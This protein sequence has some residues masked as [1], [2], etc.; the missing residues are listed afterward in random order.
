MESLPAAAL[1]GL[2][3]GDIEVKFYDD[4]LEPVPFDEPT[5]LV[6][7]SVETYTAKRA[8]QIASEYRRRG[9]PVV[10]G[11]FHASL[12]PDEVA[13]YAEAVV[14]GEA[15]TL[16][17]RVLDDARHGTLQKFYRSEGRPSLE[18]LRPDRSI[19]RGKRYLPIGLVEAGRGCHFR[20]DFC[21]VQ[22]VFNQTQTRRPIDRILDELRALKDSKR[23]FFFV[24]D[25]I[26]SNISQ[27]KEFFRALIPLRIRW[28]SQASINAAHDEEFLDLLVRSGCQGVLIGFESLNPANLTAMNK[29]FNTAKG[30]FEKALANLRRHRIRVYGTFIFGYDGD[31]EESFRPTV[32]FAQ[33]HGFYIAAFNHLTPFPGTPLYQRLEAEGRLLYE[34]WWLD[35]QYSYNRIPFQPR[36]MSPEALQ[37][38][39]LGARREFYSWSSIFRRSADTVNRSNAFMWRNFFPINAMHRGDVS[40]RDHYPLGDLSWRGTLLTAN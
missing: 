1:A 15:E 7:I 6:A 10:M 38:E 35:D 28:V 9:I 2:T 3:P 11:G 14:V 18:L 13:R 16:W 21:A 39:C 32:E 26:T 17:G 8:Y 22:T 30:G 33:R 20:C 29:T 37:R 36:G 27:A 31:S 34:S 19:F 12:C 25:N 5:D 4:R 24:D 23:I 40:L